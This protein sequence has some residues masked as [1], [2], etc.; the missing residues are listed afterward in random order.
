MEPI[1]CSLAESD[2]LE[3]IPGLLKCFQIPAQNISLVMGISTVCASESMK[4]RNVDSVLFRGALDILNTTFVE[5][6]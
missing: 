2:S 4:S 6:V 1:L 3:S 5:K